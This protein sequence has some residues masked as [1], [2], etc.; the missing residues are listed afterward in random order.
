MKR[1]RGPITIANEEISILTVCR[2]IGMEVGDDYE[3]GRNMK[4]HCP[5][6]DVYHN[7]GDKAFRIYVDNNS[8]YC[9]SC[10]TYFTPVT[11]AAAA[12]D[13]DKRSAAIELLERTGHA[14]LTVDQAWA[15]AIS[16]VEPPDATLLTEALKTYCRRVDGTWTTR[17][18]DPPVAAMFTRCLALLSQ[19]HTDA[20][21]DQWLA[22]C[23]IV[24]ART[25]TST[26]VS[27]AKS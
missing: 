6:T 14:P 9:F 4:V 12:W 1:R 7:S 24:M 27:E 19:V 5:F 23:K 26:P 13:L 11:L 17:Q 18:F 22:G 15:A 20:E 25:L 10:A 21:A 2:L 8:G 3:S 16:Y